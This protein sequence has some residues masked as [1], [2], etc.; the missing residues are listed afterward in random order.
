MEKLPVEAGATFD[1][2]DVLMVADQGEVEVGAPYVAGA[3]VTATVKSHG[4]GKKIKIIKF[5]R[6]KHSRKQMGHRQDYTE[7]EI[8]AI[9][10]NGKTSV[11]TQSEKRASAGA[12][13]DAVA[14][15]LFDAPDGEPDD[16]KK[17]SGVGPVLEKKLNALGIY[18]FSQVAAFTPEQIE[19]VD[20]RLNFKGRIERDDWL[21]Q[22]ATLA[23]GGETES[24]KKAE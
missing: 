1:L 5:R 9:T 20:Q 17:I 23:A 3:K 21:S 10:A 2:D 13:T 11:A 15:K 18:R 16:L 7:I 12:D 22:A 6:R 4:R 24:S 8:S 19:A 14:T